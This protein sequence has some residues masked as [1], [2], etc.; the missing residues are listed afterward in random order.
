MNQ[1]QQ[2]QY[3]NKHETSPFVYD[4]TEILKRA[5]KYLIDGLIIALAARY[6]PSQEL[7][8]QEILMIAV[9]AAATF[10]ILDMYTPTIATAARQGAGFAIGVKTLGYQLP[11]PTAI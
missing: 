4:T 9:V 2:I 6:I 8:W 5:F 1:D 10:A 7:K 11:L 3:T